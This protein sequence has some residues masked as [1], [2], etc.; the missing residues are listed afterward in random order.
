MLLALL[1]LFIVRVYIWQPGENLLWLLAQSAN[2]QLLRQKI[3]WVVFIASPGFKIPLL[4]MPDDFVGS[5]SSWCAMWSFVSRKMGKKTKRKLTALIIISKQTKQTKAKQL[6]RVQTKKS[7]CLQCPF[8]F[9][10]VTTA[11]CS[12]HSF[13]CIICHEWETIKSD[14]SLF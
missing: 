13:H 6:S 4:E 11:L 5:P 9:C 7:F 3:A 12:L 2:H 8:N 1:S 10:L 14:V